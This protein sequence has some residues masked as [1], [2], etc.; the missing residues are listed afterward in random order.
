MARDYYKHNRIKQ[1]RAFC[2]TALGG[3]MSKAAEKMGLSQPSVSLL[4][5]AL[6]KDLGHQLFGRQGPRIYLT[7]EGKSL[8]DLALPL[9]E[10]I[11][12]LAAAFDERVNKHISG[13]LHIA[14]SEVILLQLL[15]QTLRRYH[16][17]YPQIRVCLHNVTSPDGLTQLQ[18]GEIDLA[19]GALIRVPPDLLFTPL[20]DYD[21]V[22]IMPNDHPLAGRTVIRLEEIS[23]Y[24]LILPPRELTTAQ[25]VEMVFSQH[26]VNYSVVMEARGWQVIKKY[27][28]RD[29]GIAVVPRICLTQHDDLATIPLAR[30]F[31]KCSY[32]L[33]M[34]RGQLLSP[35][36]RRF[37]E[38]LA[39]QA[40]R[41]WHPA[42]SS[43]SPRS[44]SSPE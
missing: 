19:I 14:A 41:D 7:A 16:S 23:P 6:E 10:G 4:I 36:A 32:G 30:Y 22:L 34:R 2:H 15:A 31:P 42:A 5:R 44:A 38:M 3:S 9:V 28:E 29:I 40:L 37:V 35:A 33:V 11:D 20:C 21:P 43:R 12:G 17:A 25:M 26:N 8:L 24:G 13:E 18:A 1:L 27:V 39:P